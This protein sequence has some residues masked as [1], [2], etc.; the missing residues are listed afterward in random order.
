MND[1]CNELRS[2]PS[3]FFPK[4]AYP[5]SRGLFRRGNWHTF[6]QRPAKGGKGCSRKAR[7]LALGYGNARQG[8]GRSRQ[9]TPYITTTTWRLAP[10]L[11]RPGK[12]LSGTPTEMVNEDEKG[13]QLVFLTAAPFLGT[14]NPCLE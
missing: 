10:G 12:G 7:F 3:L 14:F 8:L 2:W 9:R 4:T 5:G 6:E 13:T 1:L 11:A